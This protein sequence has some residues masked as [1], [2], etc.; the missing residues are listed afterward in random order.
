[1]L[2]EQK[3]R[4]ELATILDPE[5][6]ISIVDLGIVADVRVGDP[7]RPAV[8]VDITPTFIGC[9]AL[10]LLRDQIGERL[11]A[12]GAADVR[13]R[14]VNEPAWS[15]ERISDAGRE[16]LRRHGVTVPG[17]GSLDRPAVRLTVGGEAAARSGDSPAGGLREGCSRE[18][19]SAEDG[20]SAGA[21][22][23]AEPAEVVACPFCGSDQTTLDSRFGP[24][25]C[26]MIYYC[27]SCRNSF[28][29]MKRV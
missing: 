24:T 23:R 20:P 17:R 9:P 28:E 13:V 16:S 26:R 22:V 7:P 25:R 15:V 4:A 29:H 3:V 6:P 5:M 21:A 12:A 10:D 8:E 14:F 1:M 19:G 27:E 11:R 2:S 18:D